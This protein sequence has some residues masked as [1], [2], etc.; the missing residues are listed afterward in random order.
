MTTDQA[1]PHPDETALVALAEEFMREIKDLT[2]GKKLEGKLNTEYGPDSRFYKGVSSSDRS[3]M[4]TIADHMYCLCVQFEELALRG[5]KDVG[6]GGLSTVLSIRADAKWYIQGW[7]ANVEIDGPRYRR[8][9]LR[10]PCQS[11]KLP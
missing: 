6:E 7:L 5:L 4:S 8:S 10:Q 9:R 1:A 11:R 3:L 2:P